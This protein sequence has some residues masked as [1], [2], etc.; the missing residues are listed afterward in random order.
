MN[1]IFQFDAF[2]RVYVADEFLGVHEIKNMSTKE[3]NIE[4][5]GKLYRRDKEFIY[6]FYMYSIFSPFS[7]YTEEARIEQS[8]LN[9]G[10]PKDYKI[11]EEMNQMV[12]FVLRHEEE[13]YV[14][15]LYK[16][17]NLVFNEAVINLQKQAEK[18]KEKNRNGEEIELDKGEF[19]FSNLAKNAKA[20]NELIEQQSKLEEAK[21]KIIKANS[22]GRTG[23]LVSPF[24]NPD[25]AL[26]HY[27]MT[28]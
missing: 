22:V 24:D 2:G 26:P 15:K 23:Q 27:T 19:S 21:N 10:L 17:N 13:S 3:Y 1:S 16:L 12:K 20:Q 11:S 4:D 28:E 18:L 14:I 8:L 9:A 6:I 7:Q 25:F 5:E